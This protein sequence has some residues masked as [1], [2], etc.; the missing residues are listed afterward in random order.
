M[1]LH[2]GEHDLSAVWHRYRTDYGESSFFGPRSALRQQFRH[3][4]QRGPEAFRILFRGQ[5]RDAE[6]P[7]RLQENARIANNGVTGVGHHGGAQALLDIDD[8]QDGVV[9]LQQTGE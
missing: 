3:L 8:N 7:C 4:G 2:A 1:R 5:H 6:T 9:R